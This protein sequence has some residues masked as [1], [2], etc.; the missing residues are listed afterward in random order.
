MRPDS[1]AFRCRMFLCAHHS[2]P[3]DTNKVTGMAKSSYGARRWTQTTAT[4]IAPNPRSE[5]MAKWTHGRYQLGTWEMISA[6][7]SSRTL[8]SRGS[9]MAQNLD[10]EKTERNRLARSLVWIARSPVEEGSD[11][12]TY[13]GDLR[14]D[15][16]DRKQEDHQSELTG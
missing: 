11:P 14:R 16:D 5:G 13:A 4:V 15:H 1:G 6:R 12:L 10:S 2:K 8:P 9:S 7:R 3:N